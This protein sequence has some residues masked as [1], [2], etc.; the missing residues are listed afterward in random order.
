MINAEPNVIT[1]YDLYKDGWRYYDAELLLLYTVLLELP[2]Q[3]I[4]VADEDLRHYMINPLSRYRQSYVSDSR[5]RTS[6]A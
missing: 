1:E 6:A 3:V 4:L 5:C 2:L